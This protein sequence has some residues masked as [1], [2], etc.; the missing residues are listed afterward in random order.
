MR[1]EVALKKIVDYCQS[2]LRIAE[3]EDWAEAMNGL[4]VENSGTV[5]R[6]TASVDASFN[7]IRM[8]REC[9]ADLMLVHHGFFWGGMRPWVNRRYEML[10]DL[11][12]GDIAIFSC[13]LPLDAHPKLGNNIL[14]AKMFGLKEIQPFMPM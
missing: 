2:T 6:I 1:K 8:A 11:V 3:F 9:G 7:T 10:R 12:E 5:T 13:H 4:Q 14:L